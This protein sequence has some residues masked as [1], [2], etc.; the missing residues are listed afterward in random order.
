MKY[1]DYVLNCS[2]RQKLMWWWWLW[3]RVVFKHLWRPCQYIPTDCLIFHIIFC[4]NTLTLREVSPGC[5][6]LAVSWSSTWTLRGGCTAGWVWPGQSGGSGRWPPSTT[7]APSRPR[8]GSSQQRWRE[9]RMIHCR[10]GETSLSGA[11]RGGGEYVSWSQFLVP[12][13]IW[14]PILLI[15]TYH[16]PPPFILKIF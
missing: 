16:H 4:S 1:L 7:T 11:Q 14:T 8:A 9:S 2:F 15:D 6:T 13:I 12:Y 10:W 5:P 3:W